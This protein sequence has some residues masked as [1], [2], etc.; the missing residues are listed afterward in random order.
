MLRL[1]RTIR[2]IAVF[3]LLCM[4]LSGCNQLT[5]T[6][7][8]S[9]PEVTL[10]EL[11]IVDIMLPQVTMPDMDK[12]FGQKDNA[13]VQ[14]DPAT[15]PGLQKGIM[16]QCVGL[17]VAAAISNLAEA[18][19][20]ASIVYEYSSSVPN[21]YVIS[22]SLPANTAFASG[23]SVTFAVSQGPIQVPHCTQKVIVTAY[24]GSSYGTLELHNWENGEW[25][26]VFSC[27]ATVGKNGISTNY[28]EGKKRTPAGEF[29]LGVALS[30]KAIDNDTWPLEI[31]TKDTCIVDDPSSSLYNT[32]QSIS[33]LPKSVSYDPIGKTLTNTANVL[34]FIEHNGNG[35]SSEN[36]VKGKGSVITI[37]GKTN[38]LKATAGCVDISS[39]NMNKLIKKLDYTR[40][41]V[42]KISAI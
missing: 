36:V 9:V 29:K 1:K 6:L 27:D 12:L 22:Q 2:L 33:D 14:T 4:M 23:V 31:V 38:A 17:P 28:G 42:I 15:I 26:Q 18:G 20:V 35:Y 34:I 24:S 11:D 16:P 37:C 25:I 3:A 8:L 21:G 41:P 7:G 30:R 40:N 32:I 39:T 5:S 10:P 19:G 13:A